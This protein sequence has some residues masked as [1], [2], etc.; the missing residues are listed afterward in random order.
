MNSPPRRPH[1]PVTEPA[2]QGAR[3]GGAETHLQARLKKDSVEADPGDGHIERG[4]SLGA[5]LK[6]RT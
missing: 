2:A 6:V 4:L 5:I 1:G 3:T